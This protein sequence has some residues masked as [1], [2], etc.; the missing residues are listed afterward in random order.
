VD[1]LPVRLQAIAVTLGWMHSVEGFSKAEIARF[2]GKSRPW[3][4]AR[5]GE[6][7]DALREQIAR[8]RSTSSTTS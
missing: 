7:E 1:A 8:Q 2:Y 5:L 3:V 6:L 4:S